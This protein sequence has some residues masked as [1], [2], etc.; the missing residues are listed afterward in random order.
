M[1]V[2]SGASSHVSQGIAGMHMCKERKY[3]GCGGGQKVRLGLLAG[4]P[5]PRTWKPL[6]GG[7][8]YTRG[9]FRLPASRASRG[10]FGMVGLRPPGRT[11]V[12]H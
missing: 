2:R 12:R 4:T 11:V 7:T 1:D 8:I 9:R 3:C 10:H 5:G 6:P